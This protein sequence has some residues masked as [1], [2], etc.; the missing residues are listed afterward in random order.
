MGAVIIVANIFREKV[1]KS[2]STLGDLE[3]APEKP[4]KESQEMY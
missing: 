2:K 3:Q 1:E 4:E